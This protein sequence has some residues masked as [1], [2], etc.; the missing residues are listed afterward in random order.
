LAV[1]EDPRPGA[2]REALGVGTFS[3][4]LAD[5]ACRLLDHRGAEVAATTIERILSIAADVGPSDSLGQNAQSLAFALARRLRSDETVRFEDLSA[6]NVSFADTQL[7]RLRFE[8]CAWASLD[9][10]DTD[11]RLA[12]FLGCEIGRLRISA[13]TVLPRSIV[14]GASIRL[15]EDNF[16]PRAARES[17]EPLQ[18]QAAISAHFAV[19]DSAPL[20]PGQELLLRLAIR[21]RRTGYLEENP[22]STPAFKD[23][24][25]PPIRAILEQ[26]GRLE[27]KNISTR[28]AGSGR[29]RVG[30]M[31]DAAAIVQ[32]FHRDEVQMREINQ[33]WSEAAEVQ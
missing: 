33:I 28:E 1:L 15:L 11:A 10:T 18:I 17:R 19:S 26:H 3:L 27:W 6:G 8:R 23:P 25:W 5:S 31:R 22:L 24:L 9:F 14:E 21:W 13:D 29:V 32:R 30:V 4:D 20:S 16:A 2:V 12:S 7:R